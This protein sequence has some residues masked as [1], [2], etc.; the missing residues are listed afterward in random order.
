[1]ISLKFKI[2][3]TIFNLF[4]FTYEGTN[5]EHEICRNAERMNVIAESIVQAS[6]NNMC[7]DLESLTE[8]EI[9]RCWQDD[10]DRLAWIIYTKGRFESGYLERIHASNCY[11]GECDPIFKIVNGEKQFVRHRARTAWQFHKTSFVT[12]EEWDGVVGTDLAATT[13]AATVAGR[14]ITYFKNRCRT[15]IGAIS[16]YATG[17]RCQWSGAQRRLNKINEWQERAENEEW[18]LDRLMKYNMC[19]ANNSYSEYIASL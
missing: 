15:E 16:M 8:E 17:K 19:R 12:N 3:A 6:K 14:V 13:L 4:T 9:E 2:L 11:T 1:M 10:R 18:V 5:Q 7:K